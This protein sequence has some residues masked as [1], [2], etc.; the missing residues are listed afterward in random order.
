MFWKTTNAI[1]LIFYL[2]ISYITHFINFDNVSALFWADTLY[3]F[4]KIQES[5]EGFVELKIKA[6]K[7]NKNFLS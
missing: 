4:L 3:F 7:K 5:R 1:V 6:K 2:R